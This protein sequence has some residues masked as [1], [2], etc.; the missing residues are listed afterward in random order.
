VFDGVRLLTDVTLLVFKRP[1]SFEYR[2]GQW[3]R[4]ACEPLGS[5][6]YHSLTLTSAPH[7]D[8][9]SVHV[10]AVGP[11]TANLRKLFDHEQLINDTA[12]PKARIPSRK[13]HLVVAVIVVYKVK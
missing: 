1:P 11:W 3:I 2:S 12:Y 4:L 10:R 9:L 7:E 5:G 8:T 13:L 6:E